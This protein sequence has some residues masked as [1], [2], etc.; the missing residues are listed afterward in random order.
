MLRIHIGDTP[1]NLTEEDFKECGDAAEGYSGS[2]LSVAVREAL[3]EPLRQC[4]LAKYFKID[5]KKMYSPVPIEDSPPCA[6]CPIRLPSDKSKHEK[7]TCKN[8]GAILMTLYDV[9]KDM[10]DV[11]MVTLKH[12]KSAL[13]HSPPS[14]SPDELTRFEDWTKEFGQEGC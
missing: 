5:D 7:E 1:N 2:D 9:P 8:C 3:M 11:P 14:V 12:F 4:Q 10:L 13:K 6:K